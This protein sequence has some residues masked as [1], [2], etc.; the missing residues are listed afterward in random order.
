[1][2]AGKSTFRAEARKYTKSS[3]SVIVEVIRLPRKPAKL[4]ISGTRTVNG[5]TWSGR[6]Y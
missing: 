2:N 4:N 3:D 5:H 1:M 6:I